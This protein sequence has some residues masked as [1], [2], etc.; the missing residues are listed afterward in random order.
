MEAK[1][2]KAD[3]KDVK[4]DAKADAKESKKD[5]QADTKAAAKHEKAEKKSAPAS[6]GS[7]VDLNSATKTDLMALPGIGDA[8]ADKIIKGRPYAN[9]A[10]LVSK[11]IVPQGTYDKMSGMVIAKQE[12]AEM[13][14]GQMKE[15][16][17][18]KK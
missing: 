11:G 13:G 15:K 18:K 2:K 12:H 1:D 4:K 16:D 17:P 8:Y 3:A 7:L 9:K 10:Q 14:K 5:A 6:T